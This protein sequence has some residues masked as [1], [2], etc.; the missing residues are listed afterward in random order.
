MRISFKEDNKLFQ[1]SSQ[2]EYQSLLL[3]YKRARLLTT[4]G[5]CFHLEIS[6]VCGRNLIDLVGVKWFY[7]DCTQR[8][9][10]LKRNS[11]RFLFR[12]HNPP[13]KLKCE[14]LLL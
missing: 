5:K 14:D 8:N 10:Y 3:F 1:L 4:L 13:D 12:P 6:K 7:F 2:F 9:C 11:G